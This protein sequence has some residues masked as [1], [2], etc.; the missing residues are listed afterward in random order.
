MRL[1]GFSLEKLILLMVVLDRDVE[2]V[3]KRKPSSHKHGSIRVA[4]A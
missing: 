4:Y 2:I 1:K 3:I